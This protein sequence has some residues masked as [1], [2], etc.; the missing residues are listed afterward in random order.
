MGANATSVFE[1]LYYSPQLRQSGKV[2]EYFISFVNSLA[3]EY[4]GRSYL[5]QRNDI[6]HLLVDTLYAEKQ[7]DTYMR[8]NALGTLQKFSLRKQA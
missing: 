5:L 8:Q 6:V 7:Q 3:S 1:S 2:K 4:L